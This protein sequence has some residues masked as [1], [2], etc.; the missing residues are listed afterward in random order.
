MADPPAADQPTT[1]ADS[2][3][4]LRPL[5][6]QYQ[7]H[8]VLAQDDSL[9]LRIAAVGI[10]A[11]TRPLLTLSLEGDA[12]PIVVRLDT[13]P[14]AYLGLHALC[15]ALDLPFEADL[16]PLVGCVV[17]VAVDPAAKTARIADG[18][19]I[20]AT[21][22]TPPDRPAP[23][24]LPATLPASIVAA[25]TRLARSR[26]GC[27]RRLFFRPAHR[28]PLL[29]VWLTARIH[30]S[31]PTRVTSP[32]ASG[33]PGHQ[34]AVTGGGGESRCCDRGSAAGRAPIASHAALSLLIARGLAQCRHSYTL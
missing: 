14:D 33:S 9:T 32:T 30:S 1:S 13:T 12:P 19:G 5:D 29:D 24:D 27:G 11:S 23:A 16:S 10:D 25:T 8:R 28:H 31:V 17:T 3:A 22:V 15:A 26:D 20:E 4:T 21:I 2:D 6:A 34:Q 7:R 18:G